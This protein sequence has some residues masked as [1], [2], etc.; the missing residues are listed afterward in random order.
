MRD[1][2]STHDQSI[3][4]SLFGKPNIVNLPPCFWRNAF[5]LLDRIASGESECLVRNGSL[6]YSGGSPGLKPWNSKKTLQQ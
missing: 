6:A 3:H 2:S 1:L 5:F 4:A